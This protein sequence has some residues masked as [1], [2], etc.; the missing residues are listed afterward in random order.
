QVHIL[1]A[2]SIDHQPAT[3]LEELK[4]IK[5]LAGQ[6]FVWTDVAIVGRTRAQ[7]NPVRAVLEEA[8]AQINWVSG[9]QNFP[10]V[11]EREI[12]KGLNRLNEIINKHDG[13]AELNACQLKNLFPKE[14]KAN[15]EP[16]RS[17]FNDLIDEWC[18]EIGEASAPV[19][20]CVHFLYDALS[21]LKSESRQ[22]AGIYM[23]TAHSAKGLEFKHVI[24]LDGGWG[25]VSGKT[26]DA[27]SERRLFYVAMTRA[28]ENLVIINISK[29]NNSFVN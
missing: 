6:N 18:F 16:W 25:P 19:E 12:Q 27:E 13:F 28:M 22:K 26:Y 8:G 3:V 17:L 15:Q 20:D 23:G 1:S 21:Q 29:L 14:E 2:K 11:R 5:K 4:R 9:D 10:L 24:I 7:L